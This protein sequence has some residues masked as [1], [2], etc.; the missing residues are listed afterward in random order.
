MLNSKT[1]KYVFGYGISLLFVDYTFGWNPSSFPFLPASTDTSRLRE[2][3]LCAQGDNKKILDVGCGHGYSTAISQGSLGIDAELD[4]IKTAQKLFPDKNFKY[5]ILS[6]MET[7]D[8]YDVVT[9][10]FYFHKIPQF[11]RK[12]IVNEAVKLANERVVIVDVSPDYEAGPEMFKRSKFL[13]DY[14]ENCRNDLSNFTETTLVDGLL[15]I[16]VYD[17]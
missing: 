12:I 2:L 8:E 6:S 17:V 4:N 1:L 11:L 5:G 13:D 3:V 15:S 14:F 16:W 7:D 10:M 9:C